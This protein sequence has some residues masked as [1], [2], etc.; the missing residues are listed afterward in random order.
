MLVGFFSPGDST[1]LN[2]VISLNSANFPGKSMILSTKEALKLAGLGDLR[3]ETDQIL[4][5]RV[6]PFIFVS[7]SHVL[8]PSP[9]F[10]TSKCTRIRNKQTDVSMSLLL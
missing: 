5:S 4:Q 3:G 7:K 10:I 9:D 1:F 2:S 6:Q 8:F